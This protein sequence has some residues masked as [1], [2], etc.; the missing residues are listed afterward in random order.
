MKKVSKRALSALIL[1]VVLV[2]GLGVFLVRYFIQG[3]NWAVFPGN[4]HTYSGG[5]LNSGILTDR[6][7]TVLLDATNGRT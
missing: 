5:N 1:A 3:D 4:P 2:L 7:D 6:S